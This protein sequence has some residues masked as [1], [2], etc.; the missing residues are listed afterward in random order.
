MLSAPADFQNSLNFY[1]L[2]EFH[3]RVV[4]MGWPSDLG[5]TVVIS[6]GTQRAWTP[7]PLDLNVSCK[8]VGHT[9]ELASDAK[10]KKYTELNYILNAFDVETLGPWSSDVNNLIN[11]IG[12]KLNEYSGDPRSHEYLIQ[13]IIGHSEIN[14]SILSIPASTCSNILPVTFLV[15]TCIDFEWF[16]KGSFSSY[17]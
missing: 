13:R 14:A 1:N 8:Q 11:K 9:T 7:T 4:R 12:L 3:A 10:R 15:T 16:N 2:H 6:F 5:R 17:N